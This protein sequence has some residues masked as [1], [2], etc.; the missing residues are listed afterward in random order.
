M[1]YYFAIS[2]VHLHVGWLKNDSGFPIS[3]EI[4]MVKQL[5][6]SATKN[7]PPSRAD[8]WQLERKKED[9]M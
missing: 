9:N 2:S 1:V 4:H 8:R 7:S 6:V 5:K 3:T